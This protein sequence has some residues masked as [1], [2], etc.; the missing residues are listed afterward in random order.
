M[1]ILELKTENFRLLQPQPFKLAPGLNLF[2]GGNAQGKTTVLEAVSYLSSGRSFRTARDRECIRFKGS[3]APPAED[4]FAAAECA[5]V[6]HEVQHDVRCAITTSEKSCWV[7]GNKLTKLGDLWGTLNTVVFIP[8]DIELVRGGPDLRRALIGELLARTSRYDLQVMQRYA[9]AL[10]ER[11]A[12]L[13]DQFSTSSEQF[14]VFETQMAEYG[15]KLLVARERLIKHFAMLAQEHLHQLTGGKDHFQMIHEP[16]WPRTANL[17]KECLSEENPM[18]SE[19][20]SRLLNLWEHDRE[21]DAERGFTQNGPHRADI[22][23]SLNDRDARTFCSQGQARSIA[24][25]LRLAEVEVLTIL[26]AETPVLLLDDIT[27]DLDQSRIEKFAEL[28]SKRGMQSL[29]TSTD[30][31]TIEKRL[32]VAAHF[33]VENGAV[34]RIGGFA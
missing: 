26:S 1:R 22:A 5:F 8:S 29:I 31:T 2:S 30:A 34:K 13:R 11:N 21:S 10:R 33:R 28:L 12:L 15:A 27:G 20:K 17:P 24:L 14:D 4:R 16:G 9:L 7:D 3:G 23:F 25:A 32:P 6:S 18:H 19:L